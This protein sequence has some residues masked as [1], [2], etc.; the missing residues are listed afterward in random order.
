MVIKT[1]GYRRHEN[2]QWVHNQIMRY[3]KRLGFGANTAPIIL[4]T[5]FTS[6]KQLKGLYTLSHAF[7]LPTRGKG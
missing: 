7:V 1:N 6:Q 3:K 2:K 4:M 5:G